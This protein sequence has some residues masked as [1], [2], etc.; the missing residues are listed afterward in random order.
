MTST[1][2][3]HELGKKLAHE[4]DAW[5]WQEQRARARAAILEKVPQARISASRLSLRVALAAAAL[6]G[7]IGLVFGLPKVFGEQPLAVLVRGVELRDPTAGWWSVEN[8]QTIPVSFSDGSLVTLVG[9]TRARV[10]S[11]SAVGAEM[12]VES[13]KAEVHVAPK[14]HA[15]WKFNLGPY[16]V[17]VLGTHFDVAWQPESDKFELTLYKGRVQIS[18]CLFGEGRAVVAGETVRAFCR[19]ERL[20]TTLGGPRDGG[21]SASAAPTP[22][23]GSGAA[24][25]VASGSPGTS[26]PAPSMGVSRHS[27][28]PKE[29]VGQGSPNSSHREGRD[30]AVKPGGGMESSPPVQQPAV[31]PALS[32]TWQALAAAHDYKGALRAAEQVGFEAECARL[33]PKGLMLLADVARYA[34]N[35]PRA[36]YAY[37]AVRHR[38]AASSESTLAAYFLARLAFDERGN[39]GQAVSWFRTYLAENPSGGLAREALGRLMEAQHRLG[40]K[41]E[42]SASA[43][44]YLAEYPMGPGAPLARQLISP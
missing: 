23:S 24:L 41:S 26:L 17:N 5:R 44:R 14:P 25:V 1:E 30:V 29:D 43:R 2:K 42:A 34:G 20:E 39:Y 3:L 9:G 32:A 4:E 10:T 19:A 28:N 22:V 21:A 11:V 37:S 27:D 12:I 13:G 31:A 40:R 7:S 35:V 38:F 33:E 36:D 18:G 16:V 15:S 6:V 8:D